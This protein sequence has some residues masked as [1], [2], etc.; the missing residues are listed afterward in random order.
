ME[1]CDYL[2]YHVS[3]TKGGKIVIALEGIRVLD[4]S[5][6]APG[7]LGSMYL[8]DMGAEVIKVEELA[9]RGG[10]ARDIF[11]PPGLSPEEEEKYLAR[12]ILG[13]NKKSIA[14]NLKVPEAREVFYK[15]AATADVIWESYRPGVVERLGISYETISKINPRIIYCS[16]SGYGQDGPYR[17]LPGHDPTYSAI[18]GV[19]ASNTDMEDRPMTSGVPVADTSVGLYAVIG[20]LCAIIAR[21]KTGRGQYI[22]VCF[23]DSA[24]SFAAILLGQNMALGPMPRRRDAQLIQNAW[25]TKDGKYIA[26]CPLESY[27]W[28]RFCRALGLEELIPHHHATGKKYDEVVSAIRDKVLTKTRDEWFEI[29]KKADTCVSPILDFDEVLE[30][31][32]ILQRNMIM[33]LEHPTQGK[34][35]QLGFA[36]KLSETPAQFR[37]F[38]PLLGQHTEEILQE[39]GYSGELVEGLIK[40]GAVK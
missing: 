5:R 7:P 4:L 28:E 2:L 14:L 12:D 10:M 31:P 24:L 40:S 22:D 17:D 33:D 19:L 20:V 6:L 34:V 21:E 8:A 29:M 18:A 32:Q 38:A 39:L 37:D 11:V 25:Q 36:I 16:I 30:D 26:S 23:A 9:E 27:F 13:R 15:L 35:K 3:I 1:S